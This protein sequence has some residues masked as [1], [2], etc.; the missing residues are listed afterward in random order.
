MSNEEYKKA[1]R[2]VFQEELIKI[3]AGTIEKEKA[4]TK[5]FKNILWVLATFGGGVAVKVV[6][7]YILLH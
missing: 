3:Q 2:E 5:L 6:V 1:I 7:E 4:S